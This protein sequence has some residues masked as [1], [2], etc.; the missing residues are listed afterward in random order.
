MNK[1]NY[2]L[3]LEI[4]ERGRAK[5]FVDV[6]AKQLKMNREVSSNLKIQ[7]IKKIAQDQ[8]ATLVIYS[9]ILEKNSITNHSEKL[10][11]WVVRPNQE[12]VN[13]KQV[14]LQDP[15]VSKSLK[16]S[17]TKIKQNFPQGD[18][19]IDLLGGSIPRTYL[20]GTKKDINSGQQTS[21]K[22]IEV[23]AAYYQLL[24]EPDEKGKILTNED[25]KVIF[26]PQGTLFEIP[27]AALYDN[28]AKQYLIEKHTILASPSVKALD[29]LYKRQQKGELNSKP[30]QNKDWLILGI[31]EAKPTQLCSQ[32]VQLNKL[33]GAKQEAKDIA[34]VIFQ[35]EAM[36][37]KTE[38]AVRQKMPQA[39]MIHL[40]THGL[41]DNCE[42][43]AEVP[44]AIALD[45]SE[46][47]DGWLTASE[48]SQMKLQAELIVLSACDTARGRLTADGVIGLSRSALAA[49]SSSAIVSLWKVEDK[50]TSFLMKEFYTQ[51]KEQQSKSGKFDKAEALRQAMLKTKNYVD[52]NTKKKI[53]SEP[54]Q[55]SAFTLVGEPTTQLETRQ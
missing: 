22:T 47:N 5:A 51:L 55:W 33:P 7:D 36:E 49:G 27:F 28:Q 44:G 1:G 12:K 14:D 45:A 54:Y 11:I 42:E 15:K 13:F 50:S 39:R 25:K 19:P 37:E 16:E 41:L 20:R 9:N 35:G 29:M 10:Y 6:L 4:A 46:N 3:A 18:R 30:L 8:Q 38:A 2:D 31:E 53:Y 32:N 43:D 40:A 26:I 24:I 52:K 17:F 21:Q 48:I 34:S 23:L